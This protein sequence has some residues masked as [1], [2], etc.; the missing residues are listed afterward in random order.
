MKYSCL[1]FKAAADGETAENMAKWADA[2]LLQQEAGRQTPMTQV[3]IQIW[4]FGH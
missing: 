2:T 4:G 1:T 3:P